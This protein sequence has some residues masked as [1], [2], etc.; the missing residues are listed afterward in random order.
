MK[1]NIF[2][3]ASLL[4]MLMLS[5][6]HLRAY[7]FMV[8]GIAYN[9]N[10]DGESVSVTYTTLSMDNYSGLTNADIPSTVS[11][12]GTDYAVTAIG[13]NAFVN[14][15]D[16]ISATI[17]N[18][19]ITIGDCAFGWSTSLTS[20]TI[21]NSVKSIG[22]NAF[23]DCR[24]L[25][26]VTIPGSTVEIGGEIFGRCSGLESMVVESENP[27]YDSRDNCN[28]II[29]TAT[30]TLIAGCKNT[31]IPNTVTAI[32]SYAF[33]CCSDLTN[34]TIPNSVI[35]IGG[36]AFSGTQWYLNQPNG[37]VY[38]GLVVY[39][40]KGVMPDGTSITLKDD[41]KGVAEGCFHGHWGLIS[42]TIPSSVLVIGD[43]AF[44]NCKGL[45]SVV[46][47][48]GNNT[49]DSRDNCN[50]II[51]TATNTLIA[52]CKNTSIPNSI[53]SIG[54]RAFYNCS[55][56]EKVSIPKSVIKIGE[57][58]FYYCTG[59]T[60]IDSYPNPSDVTLGAVVFD[61]VPT[62]TCELHV[63]SQ[64]FDAYSNA[65]QWKD[66]INII[67][68]LD[69]PVSAGDVNGDGRVNVSDVT[70]LVNMILGV[71][72]KDEQVADINGD[73]RVN[74]SDVT[75]LINIILGVI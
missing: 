54:E 61:G 19:I 11:H 62:S 33:Y 66:F 68:D 71:V 36:G 17:P 46:V 69:G 20:V 52:G 72:E 10:S 45:E 56:L 75:A 32:G 37:L 23:Y 41:T 50:A 2:K 31:S 27:K 9:V 70:T 39:A 28:A 48:I 14:C 63:L 40:Y 24:S 55:G 21:G 34:I 67:D 1:T 13:N 58:A 60:R 44:T 35:S 43:G 59:L 65:D 22:S 5:T 30:N 12:D 7:D 15:R 47:E 74:V 3:L 16:L 73:G 49:Y 57:Q 53:T 51:E 4:L 18:S 29:E 42:I 6:S 38:A 64:Y 26:S 8:D 25:I